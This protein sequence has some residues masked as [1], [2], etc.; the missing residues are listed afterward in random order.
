MPSERP[1]LALVIC[2]I[3][4][5][6]LSVTGPSALGTLQNADVP[7]HGLPAV[8]DRDALREALMTAASDSTA[9]AC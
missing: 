7:L 4:Q 2:W 8:P 3:D 9:L 1:G 5:Q 6:D